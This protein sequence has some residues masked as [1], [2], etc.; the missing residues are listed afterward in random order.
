MFRIGDSFRLSQVSV[1]ALRFYADGRRRERS[2]FQ[3]Q[4][5]LAD[6]NHDS[7]RVAEFDA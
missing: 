1:K 3:R 4:P 7:L 5:R 6:A 2:Q